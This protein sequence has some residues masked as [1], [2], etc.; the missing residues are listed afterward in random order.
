M[1]AN[2]QSFF[3]YIDENFGH[4]TTDAMK[5]YASYNRKLANLQN[6]KSFLIMCRRQGVFPAHIV[7]S[8][9]CVHQLLVE[10]GPYINKVDRT[11]NRFKKAILNLE[12][13]QTFFKIKQTTT[14]MQTLKSTIHSMTSERVAEEFVVTQRAAHDKWLSRNNRRTS[15]KLTNIVQGTPRNDNQLP[16]FN[17]RAI[18]NATQLEIPPATLH[19]LS[20]GPKF[21]LPTTSLSQVPFYHF[22]ADAERILLTNG[23]KKV[24]DK[25]RCRIVNAMQ[26]F[27]HGFHSM[28]DTRDSTTKFCV[29]AVG[30]TKMYLQSHPEIC[31]LS[32]DKGNRTVIMM[33]EDYDRKMRALVSDT[34]TYENVK[35]DP[36]ARYQNGNNSMVRRLKD[37]KLIDHRTAK[38]LSSTNATC[39]RI[40]GQPKAHKPDLPLR[41]VIPNITAPTYKLAK[42]IA[43][44]LQ[45]SF[46]SQYSTTSSFEFCGDVNQ[47][48]LPEGYIMISLDVT[49]L[50]TN[51]P[52][53]LVIRSIINRWNEVKTQI[54]L[55]LFL[56]I[57]EYCME[58][59]YFCFE[60]RY[61]KQT[62]GTAMG[63]PLSP[64]VADIVL[65]SVIKTAM[66]SLPFEITIFRK[67]VDDIFMAIP[68][69]CVQ[70]VL[71][72]FN[73][74]E[75][76]L[77]FTTEEEKENRL[78][79]LDMT[80]IR[81][82][83]QTLTTEWYAKPIASGRMLNYNSFH[84]PKYKI[85]VANNFIHRV[86]SLT[87]NK[88]LDEIAK[89]IH[90]H[91][92]QNNYPKSLIN[93]L[94]HLYMSK[95]PTP[96]ENHPQ[97]N[98]QQQHQP[99]ET[100][101]HTPPQLPP[102][103]P[104]ISEINNQL[105]H[106]T[107]GRPSCQPS[108]VPPTAA[109]NTNNPTDFVQSQPSCQPPTL[110]VITTPNDLQHQQPLYDPTS[111]RSDHLQIH[112]I[113][114][115]H[116][117]ANS[118]EHQ[119]TVCPSNEP[120]T[121][122]NEKVYRSIPYIP[123]LSQRIT[124]ILTKDYPNINITTRQHRTINQLHTKVKYPYR[125][126]PPATASQ[127]VSTTDGAAVGQQQSHSISVEVER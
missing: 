108:P 33:R 1:A 50:F 23:D 118:I 30:A 73:R 17:E 75:P 127:P 53:H 93:R 104:T 103:L 61:F 37:L 67:Y 58:A 84:Q 19:L 48:V 69:E 38:E 27:I 7:N 13:K 20:L 59:S 120:E 24:Q 31:V 35:T 49:S 54:N 60:G 45:N 57:V 2:Q 92:R 88:P 117:T 87:R 36:T 65:D 43:D 74:I 83:D 98:R 110:P 124:K 9:K 80:V 12:I 79:F 72:A 71:D 106:T 21:A 122:R 11:I 4:N 66:N 56:E 89:T 8:F 126:T 123:A 114:D 15:R 32:A 29:T 86:C 63:S 109:S 121:T 116:R 10:N 97:P 18:L 125:S 90:Q 34:T 107:P 77:Q 14:G 76:R 95:H 115:D 96:N 62:Y 82:A 64:I 102:T 16:S 113:T 47:V 6:Q 94:L 52:R 22:L 55:D 99:I 39:P 3:R 51:V 119:N 112:A 41:P 25:N 81:N 28:V 105:L 44:I 85:N 91:L 5:A 40:Y 100:I 68:R 111:D 42:Y 26:N 78:P 70:Q 46:H 101:P